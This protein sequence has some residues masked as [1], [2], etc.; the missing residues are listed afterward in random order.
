MTKL[1]KAF[2]NYLILRRFSPKTNEAYIL[3]VKGLASYYKLSPDKLSDQQIQEYFR[4][5]TGETV[6]MSGAVV[7]LF[8]AVLNAFTIAYTPA[9]FILLCF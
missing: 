3:A 7:M 8:F 9:S 6:N 2:Q 1:R 4:Y 5:L